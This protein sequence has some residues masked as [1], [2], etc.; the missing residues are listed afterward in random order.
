MRYQMIFMLVTVLAKRTLLI[1]TFLLHCLLFSHISDYQPNFEKI[2]SV[3]T[4]SHFYL[5]SEKVSC[6]KQHFLKRGY[7]YLSNSGL[8]S[9]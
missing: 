4:K 2:T 1:Y 8:F 6:D 9:I 5:L 3:N 7:Q